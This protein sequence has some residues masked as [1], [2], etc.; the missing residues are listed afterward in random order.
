[1]NSYGC[2]D[3]TEPTGIGVVCQFFLEGWI[4][5]AMNNIAFSQYANGA[6]TLTEPLME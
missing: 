6:I 3:I 5:H 1:M 4:G 2:A